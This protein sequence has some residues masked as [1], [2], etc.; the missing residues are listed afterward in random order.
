MPAGP[1]RATAAQPPA[2]GPPT[3]S[4]A[5][6]PPAITPGPLA[7]QAAPLRLPAAVGTSLAHGHYLNP[8]TAREP[9]AVL[10]AA[11]A[12]RLGVDRIW[13]GERIWLG[14]QWFYLA[15]ILRPTVLDSSIDSSVLVGFPAARRYLHFDGH[16]STIYLRPVTDPV[17]TVPNQL[18]APPT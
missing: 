9:V 14:S 17:T 2:T 11:A 16:P 18:A 3:V 12:Q 7:V 15:G 5:P 4:P 13:P 8:A 10:G 1:P 6:R